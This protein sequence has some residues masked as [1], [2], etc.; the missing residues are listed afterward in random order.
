MLSSPLPSDHQETP[1]P[2]SWRATRRGAFTFT[3]RVDRHLLARPCAKKNDQ[4]SS[5]TGGIEHAFDNQVG[6]RLSGLKRQ[7][8][9]SLLN[10]GGVDLLER[11]VLRAFEVAG[12]EGPVPGPG[13]LGWHWKPLPPSPDQSLPASEKSPFSIGGRGAPRG[14]ILL[15][16]A[17]PNHALVHRLY[18]RES[19]IYELLDALPAIGFSRE[20]VAF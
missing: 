17:G 15:I 7:T 13:G 16:F 1:L 19:F 8:T 4:S 20:D 2:E 5:P 6:P 9:S 12:V 14:K 3:E 18:W 10:F 11:G